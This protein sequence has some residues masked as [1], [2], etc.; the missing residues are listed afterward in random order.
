MKEEQQTWGIRVNK[1]TKDRLMYV[2]KDNGMSA[3]EFIDG[4]ADLIDSGCIFIEDGKVQT[5]KTQEIKSEPTNEQQYID[6]LSLKVERLERENEELRHSVPKKVETQNFPEK[7]KDLNLDRLYEIAK[8]RRESA[9]S[10]LD[11]AL[12]FYR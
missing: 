7:Q 3:G 2:I 9:Q 1:T 10:I 11:N 12:R 4:I 6:V 5:I 8:K